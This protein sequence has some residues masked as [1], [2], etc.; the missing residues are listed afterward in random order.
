MLKP[1]LLSEIPH[2]KGRVHGRECQVCGIQGLKANTVPA[3]FL[4]DLF[5]GHQQG[6]LR[7][8]CLQE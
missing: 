8:F 2:S 6:K 7:D 1:H 4:C 5:N 3:S